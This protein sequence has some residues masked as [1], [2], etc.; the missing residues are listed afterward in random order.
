MLSNIS[1]LCQRLSACIIVAMLLLPTSLVAQDNHLRLVY[2]SEMTE[3]DSEEKGSYPRLA[4]LL[5]HYRAEPVPVLFISGG[6]GLAPSAMSSLDRG[7]HII[8][9]L[10]SLEPVAMVAG[11]RE[12]S[13]GEDELSLRAYEA[14]FPVIASNLYDPLTG[15]NL[16]G[17]SNSL[18]VQQYGITLG[19]IAVI[20][21]I[22]HE[23]YNLQR[24]EVLDPVQSIITRAEQLRAAGATGSF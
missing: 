17:I 15:N 6:G 9:L 14:A 3:M 16:D 13:F 1:V 7:A 2:V 22:T 23:E 21:P 8:D 12:F 5:N 4:G 19:F 10:N 20:P 24:V 11:K 18:L